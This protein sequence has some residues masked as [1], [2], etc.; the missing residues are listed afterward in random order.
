MVK[1]KGN[2]RKPEKASQ[3]QTE[4]KGQREGKTRRKMADAEGDK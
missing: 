3:L 4:G 1:T 2:K